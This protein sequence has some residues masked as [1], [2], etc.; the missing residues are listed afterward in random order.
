MSDWTINRKISLA[1]HAAFVLIPVVA[2]LL[3]G[4]TLWS[5]VLGS[6][7]LAAPVILSLEGVAI[8]GF[9]LKL[10]GIYSPLTKARHFVPW[11]SLGTL[12]Y[13]TY[14]YIAAIH[15]HPDDQPWVLG[16]TAVVALLGGVIFVQS[17]RTIE[18]LFIDPVTAAKE[19]IIEDMRPFLERAE[20]YNKE[21]EV[22]NEANLRI[23][24]AEQERY[25]QWRTYQA[26]LASPVA[27]LK[28]GGAPHMQPPA[29]TSTNG[30]A[31]EDAVQMTADGLT[32][33]PGPGG[34]PRCSVCSG[35]VTNSDRGIAARNKRPLICGMCR[36]TTQQ[37]EDNNK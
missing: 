1:V 19:K 3:A 5:W 26:A 2:A 30:T 34:E 6:V 35:P 4:L 31:D 24:R 7:W 8:T 22:V 27:L 23:R 25:E 29:P 16:S 11:Y 14:L 21:S 17:F 18:E 15:P 36:T 13:K 37:K 9:L 20:R 28:N 12:T 10:W 32:A 33:T